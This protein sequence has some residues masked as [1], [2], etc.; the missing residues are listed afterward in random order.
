[1]KNS[2]ITV[3]IIGDK[4][5][6]ECIENVKKQ[7]YIK[8]IEII[9]CVEEKL[10]DKIEKIQEKNTDIQ[11]VIYEKNIFNAIGKIKS[12][13]NGE[14]VTLLNSEDKLTIDYYRT[15]VTKAQK[16]NADI[17]MSNVVL[18]YLD[19]GRAYLNMSEAL[20]NNVEKEEILD[21]YIKQSEISILWNIYGNKI[22]RKELFF[23]ALKDVSCLEEEVQNFYFFTVLMYYSEKLRIETNEVLFY[24]FEENTPEIL[25]NI[26]NENKTKDNV[27][28]AK[29]EQNFKY[30]E[31]F[32]DKNGIKY[33]IENWKK[34]YTEREINKSSFTKTKTAWNN[35]LE[36]LKENIISDQIK[37]VSF[38]IF[39]TLILR[40]FWTPTDL[41]VFMDKY[42]RE[43]S[44]IE[45]GIDFSKMR[46][47]AEKVVRKKIIEEKSE[48]Q[49]ITLNEIYQEIKKLTKV[50]DEIIEKMQEKEKD[51]E[52]RFCTERKTTKEI[53][54]LAKYLNKEVICTSDM[55][56]PIETIRNMLK[57][58]GYEIKN[59]YLSSEIGL[60][61][62]TKDLYKY[63]IKDLGVNENQI[64]H[65]GDNYYSDYENANSLGI[66]GQFLPKTVDVFCDHNITNELGNLFKKNIPMWENTTNGLNFIGIR[67][68]IALVANSY[69]DNPYRTFN[70]QSDFNADPNLI[71][72]YILGMHLFGVANWIM[73]EAIKNKYDKVVFF[74]RDG[75]WVMR[76]YQLLKKVYKEAPKEDYL[77][78]S[79]RALIP[80]TLNNR[81]DFYKLSE[82]I[83]IY[84]YTPKTVLKYF[85]VILKNLEN[86]KKECDKL[87]IDINKKFESRNEFDFYMNL[88]LEKFYDSDKHLE[89]IEKLKEYF[90]K[91]FEG[92]SC[93]F[94]IG[95]SA[96]PEM[97]LSK[98]C[99]K[100][101]DTYFINISNEE[102]FEHAA[103]GKFK[104]KT[105]FD[106]RPAI[107]GVIREY[108]IS[109]S[110]PS[111]I[112]YEIN[113][114]GEV[115]PV[116]EEEYNNEKSRI[117]VNAMQNKAIEFVKKLLEVFGR[118]IEQL[119]YQKYYVSLPHEMFIN[120]AKT[121]DQEIFY[122]VN[123]EDA[124][125][126]G[127]NITA[128]QEWNNEIKAKNQKRTKELFDSEYNERMKEKIV[129]LEKKLAKMQEE[130]KE[131]LEKCQEKEKEVQEIYNSKRW[132]CIEKIEKIIRRKK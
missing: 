126:L 48:R 27:V 18:E 79:R 66:N 14:Y 120:S 105:Y 49:E 19:G 59:I 50:T 47:E 94:D 22:F 118:D 83:N 103:I 43:I 24:D 71:G 1:M 75:Y 34:R 109:T 41:F 5:S 23:K 106:Y 39:D 6:E 91:M 130:K 16:E 60:T 70:N 25:R 11:Y 72:Y 119:Y 45:T 81:L 57:K 129:L 110:S 3:I 51:L 29:I 30:I 62:F 122:G 9:V 52:I 64:I 85:S 7:S 107:T 33:N 127:E 90:M 2:K 13:I 42:F 102:A 4:N 37:V 124:V 88:I 74:A 77:Y 95:Y 82:L 121:I 80:V 55:Y 99:N 63:V 10:K 117:I 20:L 104:L 38:D 56:L 21:N 87:K 76:V 115:Q 112:G 128:I 114:K 44:K 132:K 100:P 67:C 125:G 92:N 17:V 26:I 53:Y 61:K 96:K 54:E 35:N 31:E 101:I 84:K 46:I 65:I 58:T 40:P 98:L 86:L 111:C 123:L 97:Y 69:F 73:K 68:M 78:I 116:F 28:D 8:D 15:M 32:L 131:I 93:A 108:L 12:N 36:K 89:L 113:T